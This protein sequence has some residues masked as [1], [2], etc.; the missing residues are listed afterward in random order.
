MK[1]YLYLLTLL[2]FALVSPLNIQAQNTLTDKEVLQNVKTALQVGSA[3]ELARYF[4]TSLEVSL[5]NETKSLSKSEAESLMKTFFEKYKPKGF[6]YAHQG[7][8]K[9][10]IL[11]SMGKYDYIKTNTKGHLL[12]YI[13]LKKIK[14]AYLIESLNISS[15]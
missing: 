15:M 3:K 6:Q 12:V 9:S 14:D 13:Q 10:G 1:F 4:K 11:Y 7:E 2:G 8:A 5:L